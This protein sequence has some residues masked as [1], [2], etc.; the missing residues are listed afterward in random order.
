MTTPQDAVEGRSEETS[1][2]SLIMQALVTGSQIDPGGIKNFLL[3][4]I[5]NPQ[6]ALASL[7][8]HRQHLEETNNLNEQT[9]K[10]L[11]EFKRRLEAMISQPAQSDEGLAERQEYGML[12]RSITGCSNLNRGK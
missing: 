6:A 12:A 9:D 2:R 10:S 8:A 1:E 5:E 11:N 3:R 4:A 7:A